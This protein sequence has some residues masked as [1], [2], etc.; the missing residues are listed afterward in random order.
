[1]WRMDCSGYGGGHRV[2]VRWRVGYLVATGESREMREND[3]D[4]APRRRLLLL[5]LEGMKHE[6]HVFF[7]F[8]GRGRARARRERCRPLGVADNSR[9]VAD[10]SAIA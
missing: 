2:V 1:M 4:G 6:M 10:T 7:N 8:A 5:L 9:A 3:E